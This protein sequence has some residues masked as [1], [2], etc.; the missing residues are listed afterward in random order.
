VLVRGIPE[1]AT[2]TVD[3]P[4]TDRNTRLK[5]DPQK[6][7]VTSFE[8]MRIFVDAG[9]TLLRATLVSGGRTHQIRRHLDRL[10]HQ[11]IGDNKYG[12]S[13]INAWVESEFGLERIFLHA[14]NLRLRGGGTEMCVEDPLPTELAEVLRRLGK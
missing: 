7:A 11:V 12:K 1:K 14:G 13:R 3:R 4:L 10:G 5:D 6:E 8:V 9:L 2:F